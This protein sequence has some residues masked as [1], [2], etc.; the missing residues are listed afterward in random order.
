MKKKVGTGHFRGLVELN[1][2][3]TK[4]KKRF[5]LPSNWVM[6]LQTSLS[7]SSLWYFTITHLLIRSLTHSTITCGIF[8]A[9]GLVPRRQKGEHKPEGRGLWRPETQISM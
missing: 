8:G 6:S 1:E 2:L 7:N 4:V 5:P 3:K 9:L